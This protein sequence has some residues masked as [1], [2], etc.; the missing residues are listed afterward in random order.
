MANWARQSVALATFGFITLVLFIVLSAP[1]TF[2]MD[3]IHDEA[4]NPAVDV[5]DDVRPIINN[6]RLIFGLTFV[7]SMVGLVIWFLLGSHEEEYEQY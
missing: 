6:L 1:F 4:G 3:T 5:A 2:L 7:F